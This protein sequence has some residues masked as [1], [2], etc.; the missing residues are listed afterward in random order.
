M[1]TVAGCLEL[2]FLFAVVL[3][4][5]FAAKVMTHISGSGVD[6]AVERFFVHGSSIAPSLWL[7][8]FDHAWSLAS[9][10]LV[11]AMK[12][13]LAFV[14]KALSNLWQAGTRLL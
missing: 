10:A 7:A 2:L 9:G 12:G 13:N 1:H 5:V 6:F 14:A 3:V 11:S 4:A 8:T